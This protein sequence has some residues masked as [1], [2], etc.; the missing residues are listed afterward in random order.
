MNR[1]KDDRQ[2]TRRTAIGQM[3]AG[4]VGAIAVSEARADPSR[5]KRSGMQIIDAHVHLGRGM[6]MQ[7]DADSLL[8]A[9]DEAGIAFSVVCPMDRHMAV[10]NREGND[11]VLEAVKGHPDR[12]AGMAVANP[13]FGKSAV[14]E[15]RRA[16]GKGLTGVNIHS[17]LQGFRLGEHLV[18]PILEVAAKS[19]VPVYAHTGTAGLA[20]PFHLIELARRF[21][22]VNFLMGHAGASDYYNDAVRGL[23]FVRNVWLESSRNGPSN[24]C[25]WQVSNVVDRVV[26]GSSAPEYIP[27]IELETHRDVFTETADQESI[28]SKAI[29]QVYKGRLP[30]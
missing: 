11:L 5:R 22:T 7:H 17:V 13:W 10:A 8:K 21:P 28:F 29:R 4:T 23:E 24:F 12:L 27:K 18:D 19:D 1:E 20:E 9:M 15:I 30:V 3:V 26:F 2:I 14:E 6:Q 25:H 16:L